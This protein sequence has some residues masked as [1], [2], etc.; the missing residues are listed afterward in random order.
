MFSKEA[1]KFATVKNWWKFNDNT[2][3]F[4][5]IC[6]FKSWQKI[7]LLSPEIQFCHSRTCE[8]N[9]IFFLTRSCRKYPGRVPRVAKKVYACP[10]LRIFFWI[11]D[12]DVDRRSARKWLSNSD[13]L[14]RQWDEF[15]KSDISREITILDFRWFFFERVIHWIFCD[16]KFP[17]CLTIAWLNLNYVK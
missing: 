11:I 10:F 13:I 1:H 12:L 9:D 15:H 2:Q 3:L 14:T 5:A 8:K 4:F 7:H 6:D 16:V 17:A